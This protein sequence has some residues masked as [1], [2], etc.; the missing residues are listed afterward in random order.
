[1][2]FETLKMIRTF[3]FLLQIRLEH[4]CYFRSF[5]ARH[6]RRIPFPRLRVEGHRQRRQQTHEPIHHVFIRFRTSVQDYVGV[7]GRAPVHHLTS[8]HRSQAGHG[9]SQPV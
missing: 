9:S 2:D 1:M 3:L 5:V 8:P 6:R 7:Q 4:R